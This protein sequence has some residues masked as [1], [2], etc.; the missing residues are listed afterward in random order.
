MITKEAGRHP[1]SSSDADIDDI[2][3]YIATLT[4]EE[5]SRLSA[6][7]A[8]LDLAALLYDA[9]RRRGLSQADAAKRTGF[10]QQA[11]SRF[12]R[13]GTPQWETLQRYLLALGYSLELSL[14]DVA[15]GESTSHILGTPN[16][17]AD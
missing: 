1:G 8:A 10:Q 4:D 9:R 2:D 15:T 6:A 5:R 16:V 7:H 3:A 12:E 13:G 11:I 14:I 17:A